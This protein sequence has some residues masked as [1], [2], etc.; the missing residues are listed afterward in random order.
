MKLLELCFYSSNELRSSSNLRDLNKIVSRLIKTNYQ[1]VYRAR[2]RNQRILA[3]SLRVS[4]HE[5]A[6]QTSMEEKRSW[7]AFDKCVRRRY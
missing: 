7:N 1:L 6:S 3:N 4:L 2:L 5:Q